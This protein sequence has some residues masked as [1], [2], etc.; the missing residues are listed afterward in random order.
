MSLTIFTT[1][2]TM[3][4]L[5]VAEQIRDK[6]TRKDSQTQQEME[7]VCRALTGSVPSDMAPDF[8]LA[9][10]LWTDPYTDEQECIGWA[11]ATN[12][13]SVSCLQAF[14]ASEYRRMGLATSLASVL[15]VDGLLFL[16]NPLGVFS[17]E[18]V[19]IAR[20]LRFRTIY[21]Y[22]RTEDGWLKSQRLLDDERNES[23]QAVEA[24]LCDVEG[25]MRHLPLAV[26]QEG[27]V[28]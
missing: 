6:L 25:Q 7:V 10:C 26:G 22:R 17:D 21:R 28:D 8:P 27:P 23:G 24:G 2:S 13:D 18:C 3:L 11:S 12:W 15:V 16:G 14:V 19:R 20:R 4:P 5:R 1:T 9:I